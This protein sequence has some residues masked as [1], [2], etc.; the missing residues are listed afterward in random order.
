[1]MSTQRKSV[2]ASSAAAGAGRLN[3]RHPAPRQLL[4]K[5]PPNHLASVEEAGL[6]LLDCIAEL[7]RRG[8]NVGTE[9][10]EG[11]LAQEW[12][13]YPADDAHDRRRGHSYYYHCH[14]SRPSD[15]DEH[16]HF[17]LFVPADADDGFAHLAGI[18]IDA[19]GM[20]I[21]LFTT[22]GWVTG[23]R[24]L[25]AA[26]LATTARSLTISSHGSHRS[27]DR[28]LG[29]AVRFFSP[30]IAWLL[31][32]RD[33]RIRQLERSGRQRLQENRRIQIWSQCSVSIDQQ[34]G[35]LEQC[36]SE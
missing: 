18:S 22:N 16:G 2:P 21:R 33:S 7:G 17:H 32:R 11:A 19:H 34:V 28:W 4:I 25:P 30:Q 35:A 9:V 23:E 13:H 15:P 8:R 20:P 36:L 3:R 1:M 31:Q 5:L 26:T 24:L 6:E 12:Q 14:P 10:V 29:A 27:V